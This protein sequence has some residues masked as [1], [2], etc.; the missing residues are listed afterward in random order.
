MSLTVFPGLNRATTDQMAEAPVNPGSSS[1]A[2]QSA[3][4]SETTN[5]PSEEAASGSSTESESSSPTQQ[6]A[7]AS[8]SASPSTAAKSKK[9]NVAAVLES[10][11]ASGIFNSDSGSKVFA[12][13]QDYTAQGDNGLT[14]RFTFNP[15]S[16]A[17]FT[18]TLVEIEIDNYFFEFEPAN[19]QVIKAKNSDGRDVY[20]LV[21]DATYVYDEF[22]KKWSDSDLAKSTL[23][24]EV[25]MESNGSTVKSVNLA[26]FSR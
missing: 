18:N 19:K 16:Y 20:L 3:G 26:L 22:G 6:G 5:E 15:G 21:G 10:P 23:K 2:G 24:I 7:S 8:P 11:A 25:V 14:A 9:E 1:E 12:L 17:V 4:S 13:D